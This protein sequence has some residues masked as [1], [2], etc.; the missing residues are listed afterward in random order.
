MVNVIDKDSR[1][2]RNIYSY[3]SMTYCHYA[4]GH[5]STERSDSTAY[6]DE[7]F[8]GGNRRAEVSIVFYSWK[9]IKSR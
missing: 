7:I 5:C 2:K 4:E 1:E 6:W 8:E 9:A 3:N